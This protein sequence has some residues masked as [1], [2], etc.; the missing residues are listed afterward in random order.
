MLFIGVEA[1]PHGYFA[2]GIYTLSKNL[3]SKNIRKKLLGR[4]HLPKLR[5]GALFK[6]VLRWWKISFLNP[7]NSI[8]INSDEMREKQGLNRLALRLQINN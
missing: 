7:C 8:S 2:L 4:Y 5:G 6:I 3:G 1:Y